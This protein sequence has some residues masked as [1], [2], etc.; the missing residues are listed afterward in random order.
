MEFPSLLPKELDPYFS[1]ATEEALLDSLVKNTDD[2]VLFFANAVDDETWTE[3]HEE[4]TTKLLAWLTDQ[5]YLDHLSSNHYKIAS[6]AIKKH[7]LILKSMI[8]KNI[9]IKLKDGEVP[10]NGLLLTAASDFFRQ[11]LI[12]ASLKN[13]YELSFPQITLHEFSPIGSFLCTENVPDLRTRG[14]EEIVELIKRAIAWELTDLSIESERTLKKYIDSENVFAMLA[15][16]KYENWHHFVLHCVDFIN[17]RDWKFKLTI[18]SHTR[19][20]FEFLDFHEPTV[21]FFKELKP[22]ITDIICSGNLIEDPQFGQILKES[23][24][25]Y[26]LNINRTNA[27]SNHLE[28]I[29]K[30]LQALDLSECLWINNHSLKMIMKYCPN[31]HT[32]SL[33]KNVHLNYIFWGELAKFKSIRQLD[34]G[35]CDQLHDDDLSIIFRGLNLL[36]QISLS[37]CKKISERGYLELAKNLRRLVKFN[38]SYSEISDTALVEIISRCQHLTDLDIS[39]CAQLTEKGILAAIKN[40]L[41]LQHVSI[42]HCHIPSE[43][44]QEMAETYPQLVLED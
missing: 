21:N 13:S 44:I 10:F 43:S 25:L 9:L 16:A 32:L 19:L 18:P 6:H 26:A 29:P 30:A 37:G 42:A 1:H 33:Q 20:A 28:E 15:R 27:Y 7:Y 23:P 36:S 14:V 41:S 8:P 5:A 11:L 24:N 12:Q 3:N 4:L 31:L 22:L 17:R 2:L 40:G 34:L 39:G 38:A 35:N